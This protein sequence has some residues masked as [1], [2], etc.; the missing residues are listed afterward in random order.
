MAT[1]AT[2]ETADRAATKVTVTQ[3]E[4][5]SRG[6]M[7]RRVPSEHPA[8]RR[9]EDGSAARQETA[10]L[11]PDGS[12]SLRVWGRRRGNERGEVKERWSRVGE[13]AEIGE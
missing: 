5:G 12:V 7:H 4:G 3:A 13:K 10:Q 11:E 6:S 9:G 1:A 2:G 8:T